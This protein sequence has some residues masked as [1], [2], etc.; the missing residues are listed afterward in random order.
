[1][2]TRV[3]IYFFFVKILMGEIMNRINYKEKEIKNLEKRIAKLKENYNAESLK[4]QSLRNQHKLELNDVK[5][6]EGLSLTKLF[7][8]LSKRYDERLAKEERE[9]CMVL[10][11]YNSCEF[12]LNL[13]KAD[14]IQSEDELNY[15]Y[16][17]RTRVN[18]LFIANYRELIETN[19]IAKEKYQEINEINEDV[20]ILKNTNRIN[21]KLKRR[22]NSLIRV[23][24]DSDVTR[25]LSFFVSEEF[26]KRSEYNKL[27]NIRD[28]IAK[29][30]KDL[31]HLNHELYVINDDQSIAI[32]LDDAIDYIESFIDVV[33]DQ[34]DHHQKLNILNSEFKALLEKIT[35]IQID[36]KNVIKIKEKLLKRARKDLDD[37]IVK[38]LEI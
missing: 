30:E 34:Y 6:L 35:I 9:A 4:L 13:L 8:K 27:E 38:C 2:P 28:S 1:M 19:E 29:L 22:L 32:Y 20:E 36:L 11:Q 31:I 3:G 14:I 37:Y 7:L 10:A 16:E 18:D 21:S 33:F 25:V 26:S 12:K 5:E 15:L 23:S 17:K 24:E